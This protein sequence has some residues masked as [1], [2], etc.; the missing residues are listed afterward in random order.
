MMY[1]LIC[2]K[3][4]EAVYER[5]K[6]KYGNFC[7]EISPYDVLDYEFEFKGADW[8]SVGQ[9]T[10][11]F[12]GNETWMDWGSYVCRGDYETMKAFL[13]WNRVDAETMARFEALPK[14]GEYG[15]EFIEDY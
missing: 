9:N 12:F 3:F 11:K 5:D 1:E 2:G 8:I 13:E 6:D 10:K 7:G 15:F 14:E 4:N